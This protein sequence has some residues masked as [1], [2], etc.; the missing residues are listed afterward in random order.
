M[1]FYFEIEKKMSVE[2]L[3][4]FIKEQKRHWQQLQSGIVPEPNIIKSWIESC[5]FAAEDLQALAN[6]DSRNT[7]D[8]LKALADIAEAGNVPTWF[9]EQLRK[10]TKM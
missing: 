4:L 7:R 9:V 3:S 10:I 5:D 2:R 1:V 6:H 8:E